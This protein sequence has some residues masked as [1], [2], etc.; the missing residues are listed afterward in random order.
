VQ[1]NVYSP[2]GGLNAIYHSGVEVLGAEYVYGGGDTSFSGVTAQR[3]KVPPPGSGWVFYQ[4]VSLGA[5][6]VSREEVLRIVTEIRRDFPASSY[7]LLSRNCNHFSDTLSRRL[8]G[9]GIPSWVNRAAGIGASVSGVFGSSAPTQAPA[10]ADGGAGGPAAAGLVAGS[11]AEDGDLK[12]M[13]R[14]S[15]VGVDNAKGAEPAQALSSGGLVTSDD[16][17]TGELLVFL[18]MES[19]VKLQELWVES[20]DSSSAP[21]RIRLFANP[22][23]LNVDDAA[24]GV[25]ATQEF[26]APAWAP[27][28]RGTAVAVVLK[29]NFLKFQNL[30]NLAVYFGRAEGE[31]EEA[32]VSVQGFRLCGK[33]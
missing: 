2:S 30:G 1:L 26:M 29:V 25:A 10:K 12:G 24:G 4:A 22:P 13:V 28:G 3:P 15:S 7:D 14:W 23:S 31:D 8:C 20:P 18:P 21:S 6:R 5:S 11:V 32:A 16:G 9:Q 19:P 17:S 27:S 33:V